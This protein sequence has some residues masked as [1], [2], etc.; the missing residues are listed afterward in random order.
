MF[1]KNKEEVFETIGYTR[2]IARMLFG[3]SL[4]R[5]VTIELK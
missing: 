2:T 1:S 5:E 4:E 3:Q